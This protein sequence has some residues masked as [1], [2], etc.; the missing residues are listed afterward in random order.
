MVT[1]LR[2]DTTQVLSVGSFPPP[3]GATGER[4][5]YDIKPPLGNSLVRNRGNSQ[6]KRK[7]LMSHDTHE[8]PM[9]KSNI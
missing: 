9:T 3:I 4:P 2:V 1:R 5:E 6:V 8:S 7:Q